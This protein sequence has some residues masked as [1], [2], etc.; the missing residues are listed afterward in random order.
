M[1]NYLKFKCAWGSKL[2]VGY[3]SYPGVNKYIYK[4]KRIFMLKLWTHFIGELSV[5]KD[6]S[7]KFDLHSKKV[8]HN[9]WIYIK[10][11]NR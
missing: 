8:E 9:P 11:G 1:M 4:F 7:V 3:L 10:C 2:I 6:I 5:T